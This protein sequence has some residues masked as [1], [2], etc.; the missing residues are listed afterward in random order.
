VYQISEQVGRG[1]PATVEIPTVNV[2]VEIGESIAEGQGGS[3]TSN[4]G[5]G[6]NGIVIVWEYLK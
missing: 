3:G 6:A 1:F 2:L 4:G 5:D